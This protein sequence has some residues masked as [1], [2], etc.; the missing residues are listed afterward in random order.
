MEHAASAG[1]ISGGGGVFLNLPSGD[2]SNN[3]FAYG[4][5]PTG[6]EKL[7]RFGIEKLFKFMSE[8]IACYQ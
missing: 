2:K 3:N 4:K 1:A 6:F 5:I 8:I 7:F